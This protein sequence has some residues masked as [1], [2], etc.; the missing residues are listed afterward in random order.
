MGAVKGLLLILLGAAFSFGFSPALEPAQALPH[1]EIMKLT[2]ESEEFRLAEEEIL[3][4]WGQ[5]MKVLNGQAKQ[6]LIRSQQKWIQTD[7]DVE[8]D[9][10]LA[11]GYTRAKAYAEVT[12]RKTAELRSYLAA[13][14]APA[15]AGPPA[16]EKVQDTG[17]KVFV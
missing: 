13:G 12:R 14:P 4:V 17:P 11:Q 9:R 7:R 3:A 10:L 2:Q 15:K 6:D 5:V 16:G 1:A 8:A